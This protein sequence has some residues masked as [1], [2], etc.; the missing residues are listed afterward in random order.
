M[1]LQKKTKALLITL[2]V[3]GSLIVLGYFREDIYLALKTTPAMFKAAA[4]DQSSTTV[5]SGKTG[6]DA[7]VIQAWETEVTETTVERAAGYIFRGKT[8]LKISGKMTRKQLWSILVALQS[9]NTNQLFRLDFSGTAFSGNSLSVD[10]G[11]RLK[12]LGAI[13][14]PKGVRKLNESVFADAVNLIEIELPESLK[15]I[16]GYAFQ[17]TAYTKIV[18]P[19]K[20]YIDAYCLQSRHPSTV[21][22]REGRRTIS[23]Y[24]FYGTMVPFELVIPPSFKTFA[25][26]TFEK[27]EVIYSYASTP[28]KGSDNC[29]R[30]AKTIYCPD[31]KVYEDAWFNYTMAEFKPLPSDHPTIESWY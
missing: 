25:D 22:L 23:A 26:G 1:E 11:F 20:S 14:L 29:L 24:A 8:N 27:C 21:V 17:N 10:D 13:T 9:A 31:P 7:N 3:A 15:Y 6:A 12:N 5:N 18:I 19:S 30:D 28:P 16:Y 2:I 4:A